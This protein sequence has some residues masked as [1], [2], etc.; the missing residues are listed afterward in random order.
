MRGGMD[1]VAA[2]VALEVRVHLED[3]HAHAAPGQQQAQDHA[4]RPA[5]DDD[6]A[7]GPGLRG[8][9]LFRHLALSALLISG[10]CL[11]VR[12]SILGLFTLSY[13][14][15]EVEDSAA[16]WAEW[17]FLVKIQPA[18]IRQVVRLGARA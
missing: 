7:R 3:L 18:S 6:A 8:G 11:P 9:A 5:A 15:V 13:A 4:R 14:F 16:L 12:E 1:G 10:E 17:G 2:E